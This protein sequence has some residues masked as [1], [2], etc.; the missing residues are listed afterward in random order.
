MTIEREVT[1]KVSKIKELKQQLEILEKQVHVSERKLQSNATG[2]YFISLP[3]DWCESHGLKKG[4]VV[5]ISEQKDSLI[6]IP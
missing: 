5:T 2:T 6:I 3:K 4:S 1:S